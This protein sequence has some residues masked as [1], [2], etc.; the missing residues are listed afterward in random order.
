MINGWKKNLRK[1]LRIHVNDLG[2][3]SELEVAKDILKSEMDVVKQETGHGDL[4][5][6]QVWQESL[7]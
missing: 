4:S 6:S 2:T 5:Y 7:S 3:E 1:M